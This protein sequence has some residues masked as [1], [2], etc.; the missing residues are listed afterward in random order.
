MLLC[1]FKKLVRKDAWLCGLLCFLRRQTFPRCWPC[2]LRY[3]KFAIGIAMNLAT[4]LIYDL[5]KDQVVFLFSN[6]ARPAL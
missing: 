6:H 2:L 3:S 5:E 4:D 1:V